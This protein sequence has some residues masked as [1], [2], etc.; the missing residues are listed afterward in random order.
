MNPIWCIATSTKPQDSAPT[1][2]INTSNAPDVEPLTSTPSNLPPLPT[3]SYA[4]TL[5][6]P[7]TVSNSCLTNTTQASAWDC[8]TGANLSITVTMTNNIPQV[9]L[10]YPIPP[11][12]PVRYGSQPPQFN[13]QAPMMLMESR[14]NSNKGP[15]WI[16]LQYF[17]K[18]VIL[19]QEDLPSPYPLPKPKRSLLKRWFFNDDGL[20]EPTNLHERDQYSQW[21]NDHF[22]TPPDKPWYCFWNGTTLEGLI[23]VT[24]NADLDEDDS[25]AYP[26]AAATSAV[27]PSS[28]QDPD[29]PSASQY[30]RQAPPSPS[31][32]PYPKMVKIIE[33]RIEYNAVHP[34][35]QQMQILNTGQPA[36]LPDPVNGG[37]IIVYLTETEPTLHNQVQ[38]VAAGAGFP[39]SMP[40]STPYGQ[41]KRRAN[42]KR[43]TPI[44][45]CQW[46]S[47]A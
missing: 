42:S 47:G 4:I 36:P 43:S 10:S 15:A 17:N 14:A 3:G 24:Q 26:S 20:G 27:Y 21:T 1:T 13:G 16:F 29:Q 41:S 46:M 12:T 33:R 5:D 19:P 22:A 23:F 34:Y 39:P 44:C 30:K 37:P 45:Q 32:S 9:Q 11:N 6:N 2:T 38:Q 35:C 25:T 28:L 7:G 8:A 18:T 40:T 31:P